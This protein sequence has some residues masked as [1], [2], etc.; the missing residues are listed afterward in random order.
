MSWADQHNNLLFEVTRLM[1][2]DWLLIEHLRVA[3]SSEAKRLC[4][5][6]EFVLW[7]KKNI[8]HL[9]SLTTQLIIRIL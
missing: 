6:D 9:I 5:Y 7:W 3:K 1:A 4:L 2:A 8:I